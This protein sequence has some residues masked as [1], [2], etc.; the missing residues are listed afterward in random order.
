MASKEKD[1]DYDKYFTNLAA[2]WA[3]RQLKNEVASRIT[4]DE[5][6]VPYFRVNIPVQQ[7]DEFVETY[8]V[9]EGDGMYVAPE[10]RICVW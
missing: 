5:H 10:D 9:K 7:F 3:V 6:P 1:F 8:G 4:Q 2:V